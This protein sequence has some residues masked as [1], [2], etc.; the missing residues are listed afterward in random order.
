LNSKDIKEAVASLQATLA[1]MHS[2]VATTLTARL[3][4][5]VKSS[6]NQHNVRLHRANELG[7]RVSD[8]TDADCIP[9]FMT[10]D[11]VLVARARLNNLSKLTAVWC[12][13]YRVL[14][15][16]STHVYEVEHLVTGVVTTTH[17]TRLRFYADSSLDVPVELLD[18][19]M[20]ET[21][22]NYEYNI[23]TILDHAYDTDDNCY[24][25]RIHWSGFSELEHTW[26]PLDTL[27]EDQPKRVTQYIQALPD[28]DV[29]KSAMLAYV[30]HL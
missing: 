27:F 13:P 1:A 29:H 28:D 19:L 17:V 15:A 5:Q 12:G 20:S 16:I 14:R 7:I 26:E 10:G 25:F 30:T 3:S 21:S 9:N 6:L 8:L 18:E 22:L 4:T 23:E 2:A 11:F 24:K